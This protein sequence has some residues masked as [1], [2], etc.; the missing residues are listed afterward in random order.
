[1]GT[2]VVMQFGNVCLFCFH[3]D[4]VDGITTWRFDLI[5]FLFIF[6]ATLQI[7]K[8]DFVQV[9]KYNSC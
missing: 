8:Q 2:D 5:I 9:L 3:R 7:Y 6:P 4:L 1:M